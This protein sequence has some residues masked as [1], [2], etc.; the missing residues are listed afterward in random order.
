MLGAGG[1]AKALATQTLVDLFSCGGRLV[2]KAPSPCSYNCRAAEGGGGLGMLV[3]ELR[4]LIVEAIGDG[5]ATVIEDVVVEVVTDQ[6][7]REISPLRSLSPT[8]SHCS[9]KRHGQS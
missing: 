7:A 4:R 3:D 5:D 2:L 9:I 1:N 6:F 8:A